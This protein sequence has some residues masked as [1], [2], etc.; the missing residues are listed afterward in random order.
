MTDPV[1]TDALRVLADDVRHTV[2]NGYEFAPE[3][4]VVALR[5]AADEVDRLREFISELPH[6]DDCHWG[7]VMNYDELYPC[8]CWK[9]DAL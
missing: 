4:V 1:D 8:T 6:A 5:A 2:D 9:A 3:N 7:A